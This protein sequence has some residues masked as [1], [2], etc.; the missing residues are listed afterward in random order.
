[1]SIRER[2]ENICEAMGQAISEMEYLEDH[3][4]EVSPMSKEQFKEV[5]VELETLATNKGY[6]EPTGRRDQSLSPI[7]E[8]DDDD[9]ER[10]QET[11]KPK[12]SSKVN[13]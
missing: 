1:M 12:K 6:L 7:R 3:G 10:E 8:G 9:E 2:T 5:F 4:N 13:L 11:R